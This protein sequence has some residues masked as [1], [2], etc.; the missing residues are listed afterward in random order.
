[1]APPRE[2][3]VRSRIRPARGRRRTWQID[4]DRHF[5]LPVIVDH[6]GIDP[7]TGDQLWWI[8]ATIDLVDDQPALVRMD[9]RVPAGID[10]YRMQREFRWASP[11]EIVVTGVPSLL[12]RGIDPFDVDLPLTGFPQ[13]A[14]L[15]K[16]PNERLSDDFLEVIVREYLTIGRGYAR[17]IAEERGVSERTVVSWVEKARRRGIL[18]RVP[19]G[20]QGGRIVAKR[21]R[22]P[23]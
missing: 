4:A 3:T 1:M 10:P 19:S 7:V 17:V 15:D 21:R 2:P 11:L 14:T 9:A 8:E 23:D 6:E 12:R 20:S 22:R 5:V 13:A 16:P 18:T